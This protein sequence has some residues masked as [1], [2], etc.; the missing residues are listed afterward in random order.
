MVSTSQGDP[1]NLSEFE[2]FSVFSEMREIPWNKM[3]QMDT[4]I[5][6]WCKI[7]S[8]C[9]GIEI[10]HMLVNRYFGRYKGIN[11]QK[12]QIREETKTF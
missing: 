4:T 9:A 7:M 8:D 3:A 11:E 5:V 2:G 12:I 1:D 6:L 10:I